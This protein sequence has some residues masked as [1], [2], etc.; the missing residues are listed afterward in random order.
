[1]QCNRVLKEVLSEV[2]WK[3]LDSS[4]VG[5]TAGY[6]LTACRGLCPCNTDEGKPVVS[7]RLD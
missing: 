2:L 3:F 1:M 4:S 6:P 5:I 7:E